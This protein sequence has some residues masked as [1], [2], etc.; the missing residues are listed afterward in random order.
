MVS[1]RNRKL[2]YALLA[3]PSAIVWFPVAATGIVF[4]IGLLGIAGIVGLRAIY[5]LPIS[6]PSDKKLY[7]WLISLGLLPMAALAP[8]MSGECALKGLSWFCVFP[9]SGT[10]L[11]LVGACLLWE[12]NRPYD[13][14]T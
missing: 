5:L 4:I 11:L 7:T 6:E 12:I 2:I 3:A 1:L 10:A 8:L 9:V 14:H 13:G